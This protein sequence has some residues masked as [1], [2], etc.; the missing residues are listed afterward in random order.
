MKKLITKISCLVGV[1]VL[2]GTIVQGVEDPVE[3]S[4]P[5]NTPAASIH[6]PKPGI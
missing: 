2:F 6:K 4:V 1:M 3:N 5:E